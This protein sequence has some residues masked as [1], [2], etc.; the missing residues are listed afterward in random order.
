MHYNF[1]DV[2]D[3]KIISERSTI[4]LNKTSPSVG[5]VVIFSDGT[6]R[7]ISYNWGEDV[8]TSDYGS[9]YLGGEFTS[10]SGSLCKSIPISLLTK[11]NKKQLGECWFF[12]HNYPE[13]HNGVTVKILWKV[14]K[15]SCLPPE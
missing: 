3:T 4:M 6:R 9:F 1:N 15:A 13:A 8:Q 14:W 7:R 12:H 11:T 5:D 10:F 2:K